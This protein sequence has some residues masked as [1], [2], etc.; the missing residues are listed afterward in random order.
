MAHRNLFIRGKV[1]K[2]TH[3]MA[4]ENADSIIIC[5]DVR[6]TGRKGP[7]LRDVHATAEAI[8]DPERYGYERYTALAG[9]ERESGERVAHCKVQYRKKGA[10]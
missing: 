1:R 5:F 3:A 9:R 10:K 8:L 2:C 4:S 7:Y 6:A